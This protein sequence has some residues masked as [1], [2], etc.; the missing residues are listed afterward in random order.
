MVKTLMIKSQGMQ[1]LS[2]LSFWTKMVTYNSF[3]EYLTLIT[4]VL[5]EGYRVGS[6]QEEGVRMI[7]GQNVLTP[8]AV[9]CIIFKG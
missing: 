9:L 4:Q 2:N 3:T 7:E 1:F 5:T 8:A 6:G